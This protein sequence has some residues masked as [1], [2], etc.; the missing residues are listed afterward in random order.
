MLRGI[1]FDSQT[2]ETYDSFTYL[3]I[4][5]AIRDFSLTA[6]GPDGILNEILSHL[7]SVSIKLLLNFFFNNLC[8]TGSFSYG[9]R[10]ATIIPIPNR[11][12]TIENHQLTYRPI[13]LVR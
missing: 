10:E 2:S 6:P 13:A 8:Q 3:E 12:K 4:E 11:E 1:K 9:W 7:P 5:N